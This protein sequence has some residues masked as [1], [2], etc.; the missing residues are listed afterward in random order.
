[1]DVVLLIIKHALIGA[2]QL[3]S[4]VSTV[5]EMKLY[6]YRLNLNQMNAFH[7]GLVVM[8]AANQA[9]MDA[10]MDFPVNGGSHIMHACL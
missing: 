7:A 1:M 3:M 8:K 9:S 6:G 10:V 4:L 5:M 2:V